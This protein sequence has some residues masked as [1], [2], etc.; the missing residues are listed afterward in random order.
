MLQT[1]HLFFASSPLLL[2]IYNFLTARSYLFRHYCEN[3]L[4]ARS[5][6]LGKNEFHIFFPQQTV[7]NIFLPILSLSF[8]FSFSQAILRPTRNPRM[9]YK[10]FTFF[11]FIRLR[12]IKERERDRERRKNRRKKSYQPKMSHGKLFI[13]LD[14]P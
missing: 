1:F 4:I 12:K 5:N 14:M 2:H 3:V 10:I 6:R 11:C 13:D 9:I 8:F 7:E